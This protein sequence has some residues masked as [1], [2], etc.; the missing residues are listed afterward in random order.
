MPEELQPIIQRII[1]KDDATES[2]RTE[3]A[4]SKVRADLR[5]LASD[6][7]QT[8]APAGAAAQRF[9]SVASAATA[10]N[11]SASQVQ[12]LTGETVELA[13][14]AEKA[15]AAETK[16]AQEA[17]R[18][19]RAQA[20]GSA[21]AQARS[22]AGTAGGVLATVGGSQAASAVSSILG[23]T[24]TLGPVGLAAGGLTVALGQLQTQM[25]EN[26]KVA[27]DYA[28]RLAGI[29]GLVAAG[30]TSADITNRV[31]ALKAQQSVFEG[32]ISD[33][34]EMEATAQKVIDEAGGFFGLLSDTKAADTL[35]QIYQRASDLTGVPVDNIED[36]QNLIDGVTVKFNETGTEILNLNSSLE[37]GLFLV[38]DEKAARDA[39]NESLTDTINKLRGWGDALRDTGENILD[40]IFQ[41]LA[42]DLQ[43]L[44][45]AQS[46]QTDNYFDALA[47]EGQIRDK[48]AEIRAD[49]AQIQAES[50]DKI[51]GVLAD[52]ADKQVEVEADAAERRAEIIADSKET[53]LR[54]ERGL[55]RSELNARRERDVAAAIAAREKAADDLD[56]QKRRDEKALGQVEKNLQ[57]QEEAIRKGQEKQIAAIVAGTQTQLNARVNALNTETNALN[58]VMYAQQQIALTGSNNQRIIHTQ[59]WQDV[60]AIAVTWAANTVNTLR[61]IFSQVVGAGGSGS[62][63]ASLQSLVDA[64]VRRGFATI[65]EG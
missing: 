64:S 27:A 13:G 62:S 1:L 6:T 41:K 35:Q 3:A 26:R 36:F 17:A 53:I 56:D 18:A 21:L 9:N 8:V 16:L 51:A 19:S 60:N 49:I 42:D 55:A 15:A 46:Q 33:L 44:E 48:I 2:A 7:A 65:F 28:E 32:Q 30:E 29:A 20:S 45:D 12:S 4:I 43:A 22:V 5:G 40:K 25:E 63:G 14:A 54:I 52:S 10:L 24:A 47:K 31:N 38:N 34:N 37:Q 57:K 11:L 50:A 61:S 23:L 39:A 59:M 58:N